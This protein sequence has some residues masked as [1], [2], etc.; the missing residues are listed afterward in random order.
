MYSST[1]HRLHEG[2]AVVEVELDH[3]VLLAEVQVDRAR[4]HLLEGAAGVDRADEPA[5]GGRAPGTAESWATS[6][7]S[8]TN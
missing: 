5:V 1:V 4:V 8:R 2:D 7:A 3:P 6:S